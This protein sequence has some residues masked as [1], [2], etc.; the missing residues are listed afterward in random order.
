MLLYL[1]NMNYSIY[2]KA[3]LLRIIGFSDYDDYL[4]KTVNKMDKT[5]E[6]KA[7]ILKDLGFTIRNGKVYS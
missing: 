5:I 2:D 6:E 1:I 7:K 3:S 4:I